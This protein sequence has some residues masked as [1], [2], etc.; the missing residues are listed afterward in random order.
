VT[1]G[2]LVREMVEA[3]HAAARRVA[4]LRENG[5]AVNVSQES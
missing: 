4:V 5:F 3:D 1:V 2:E